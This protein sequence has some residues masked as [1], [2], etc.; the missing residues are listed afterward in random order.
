MLEGEILGITGLAGQGQENLLDG[1]FGMKKAEY[2]AVYR[3][4][5]LK[6]GDTENLIHHRIYYLSED[7]G[8][9]SLLL[10]SPIWENMVFGTEKVHPEFLRLRK[11]PALSFL[12]HKA[13]DSH[14]RELI[15]RLNIV[16]R[17]PEQKVRELSGG[18]QQKVCV[19]RAITFQPELLLIGE[20]TRGIDV[21]SKEL[22]LQWLLKI[23]KEYHTTLVVASGELEELLRICDR[24]AVMHQGKVF[25]I[26]DNNS[27]SLEELTLALYGRELR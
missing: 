19:S 15:D 14:S 11:C 12:N 17:G 22:I 2:Q 5:K 20:P 4:K 16:C 1:L 24:I 18:N 6:P 25:K 21:Y 13:V 9:A 23:N 26:F 3:G 7:R 8:T 27:T 10:D